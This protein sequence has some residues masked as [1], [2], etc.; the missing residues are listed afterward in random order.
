MLFSVCNRV[1]IGSYEAYWHINF[2]LINGSNTCENIVF[3]LR[4]MLVSSPILHT[5]MFNTLE[6][7]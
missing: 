7:S 5:K 6:I 4:Q 3:V 1:S 2:S